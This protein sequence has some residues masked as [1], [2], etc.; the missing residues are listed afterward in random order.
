MTLTCTW[1]NLRSLTMK[2]YSPHL[3]IVFYLF[4]ALL[5]TGCNKGQQAYETP[6]GEYRTEVSQYGITW[7]FDKPV[8]AGQ[9][10]T[11]D[12]WVEGPV[13]IV[14]ITPA[15]GPVPREDLELKVNHW[16]DT[17]LK[18]DTAMR[19]GS[20]IVLKVGTKQG[21]DSRAAGYSQS[22]SV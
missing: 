1:N 9:F 10:V 4:A 19:N 3:K 18:N 7:T 6:N 13:M 2:Y 15:P 17:S 8:K 20:M 12:W 22:E 21:D 5:M 14:R 16:N 11:G